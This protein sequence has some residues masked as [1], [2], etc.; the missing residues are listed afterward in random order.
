MTKSSAIIIIIILFILDLVLWFFPIGS[1]ILFAALFFKGLREL[2]VGML[3]GLDGLKIA[4]VP[5]E[6]HH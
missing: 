1:T 5:F 4:T 2:I 6:D 3:L